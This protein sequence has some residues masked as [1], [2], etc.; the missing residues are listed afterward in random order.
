M[1]IKNLYGEV[2][3]PLI[4]VGT[5][6]FFDFYSK[7]V[8]GDFGIVLK[9]CIGIINSTN[10]RVY[11]TDVVLYRYA[12]WLLMMAGNREWSWKF[13]SGLYKYKLDNVLT[14]IIIMIR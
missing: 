10:D 4:H 12:D 2:M 3:M 8:N 14:A 9:K 1:N 5:K 6:T 7:P 13:L 11:E